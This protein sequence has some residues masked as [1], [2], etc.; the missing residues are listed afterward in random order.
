MTVKWRKNRSVL[1]DEFFDVF[2]FF[3]K[4]CMWRYCGFDWRFIEIRAGFLKWLKVKV[5]E[6]KIVIRFRLT[7]HSVCDHS[8]RWLMAGLC[9]GESVKDSKPTHSQVTKWIM[10]WSCGQRFI[11][12]HHGHECRGNFWALNDLCDLFFF[13]WTASIT[14]LKKQTLGAQVWNYFTK[15]R[16]PL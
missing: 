6:K 7:L 11:Y 1:L 4:S 3:N 2:L 8:G 13:A 16:M 15:R 9:A 14:A 5:G 10:P 12:P